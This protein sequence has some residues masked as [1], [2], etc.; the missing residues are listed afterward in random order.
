[1]FEQVW[2]SP[3]ECIEIELTIQIEKTIR[4]TA[5]VFASAI[6]WVLALSLSDFHTNRPNLSFWKSQ[7]H[8]LLTLPPSLDSS[9]MVL[10]ATHLAG[11][12]LAN[13]WIPWMKIN[14]PLECL[15][16]EVTDKEKMKCIVWRDFC[17]ENNSSPRSVQ[18]CSEVFLWNLWF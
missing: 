4:N 12:A 5:I 6:A 15:S 18:F 9:E 10:W 17:M 14:I 16:W 1:M 3:E 11:W 2:T 13:V 7:Q 8:S